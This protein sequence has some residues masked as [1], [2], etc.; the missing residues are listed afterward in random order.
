MRVR[1]RAGAE[2]EKESMARSASENQVETT[3]V[4]CASSRC[5]YLFYRTER[6]DSV[7]QLDQSVLIASIRISNRVDPEASMTSHI[8]QTFPNSMK[9]RSEVNTPC[10]GNSSVALPLG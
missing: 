5:T 1:T 9:V 4:T 2:G 7:S 3:E 10:A 8:E 6:K